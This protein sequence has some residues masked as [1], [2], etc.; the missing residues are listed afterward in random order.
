MYELV[1]AKELLALDLTQTFKSKLLS[2]Q[3]LHTF[4]RVMHRYRHYV[5]AMFNL[6]ECLVCVVFVNPGRASRWFFSTV[7][8]LA[9][10]SVGIAVSDICVML[11]P[12]P[13][14]LNQSMILIGAQVRDLRRVVGAALVTTL[15]SVLLLVATTL[16]L[17]DATHEAVLFQHS[18]KRH[19]VTTRDLLLNCVATTIAFFARMGYRK[20]T[21]VRSQDR[22]EIKATKCA[23]Y[24]YKVRLRL[25]VSV[26]G[27]ENDNSKTG[28]L[29]LPGKPC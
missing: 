20:W 12:L 10:V 6:G 21:S 2:S 1:A 15:F 14:V 3:S 19:R 28:K 5:T 4:N 16:Q 9:M 18:S 8:T 26:V 25:V 7:N 29:A 17:T 22:V 27:R 13:W 11:L 23:G 24:D